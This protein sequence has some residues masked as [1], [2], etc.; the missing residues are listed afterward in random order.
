MPKSERSTARYFDTAAFAVVLSSLSAVPG[1]S[2][3]LGLL[4][5]PPDQRSRLSEA[6]PGI[7]NRDL[8]PH[9]HPLNAPNIVL[10]TPGFG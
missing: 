7:S 3:G 9:Q 2:V 4:V 5:D 6:K 8:Q 1:N 10:G